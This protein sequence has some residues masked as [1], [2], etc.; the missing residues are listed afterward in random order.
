VPL[1]QDGSPGPENL[2]GLCKD[3]HSKVHTRKIKTALNKFGRWKKYAALSVL[4]QII[5]QLYKGL[6]ERFG[7][8]HVHLCKSRQTNSCREAAGLEKGIATDALAI[9]AM[10]TGCLASPG[11]AGLFQVLQF[12]RHNRAI[13]H[14]QRE[15]TY[16]LDGKVVAKNRRPRFEQVGPSLA[17]FLASIDPSRRREVCSSLRVMPSKRYYN[18]VRRKV[19]PGCIFLFGGKRYIL[20]GQ[21]SHGALYRAVGEGTREFPA[22]QCRVIQAGG[23]VF[24]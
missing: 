3:C 15:R 5:P 7:E 8:D 12:R 9:A 11:D 18:N 10:P 4:N 20:S 2:I 19:L 16:K 24:Q 13:I 23:L 22:N 6:V 1:S 14:S 21:H 17:D